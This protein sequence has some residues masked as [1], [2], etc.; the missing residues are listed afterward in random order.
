LSDSTLPQTEGYL[1]SFDPELR[2]AYEFAHHTVDPA[3]VD[4]SKMKM[5]PESIKLSGDAF[6]Y[7]LQGEGPT[8]GYPA[9]FVRL[10]VCNLK[11][12][13]CDAWYT[14]NPNSEE[15]WTEGYDMPIEQCVEELKTLWSGP[16][17]PCGLKKRVI[18]T[19]GEPLIQRKQISA[20][21]ELMKDWAIEIETNGTLMP[22]QYLLETAQF[23]C[24]PKLHNSDNREGSRLKPKILD[25]LN[26]ADTTFKFVCM[27]EADLDEIARDFLPYVDQDKVIIMPQGI[28]EE[29]VSMNAKL[30]AEPCKVRGLRLMPR[31]QNICW[32]GA[33][34]GV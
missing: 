2:R 11:C 3:L 34:R 22:T 23:N 13:W 4:H 33:R 9:I 27:T 14:W 10:H 17:M 1:E 15:F 29:E 31:L 25:A 18:W 26:E 5:H 12:S 16:D 6:F 24:S 8:M 7:T 21:S 28:T 19:G 20:A 32:D 30:L